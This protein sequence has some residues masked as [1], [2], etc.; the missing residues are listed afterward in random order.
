MMIVYETPDNRNVHTKSTVDN[1]VSFQCYDT[2]VVKETYKRTLAN[3]YIS[4]D[5]TMFYE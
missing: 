5:R 3:L 2:M 4:M 1:P